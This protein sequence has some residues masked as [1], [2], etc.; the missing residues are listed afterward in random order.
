MT[1]DDIQEAIVYFAEAARRVKEAG[2]DMIHIHGAHGYLISSFL[3]PWANKRTDEYGGSL[4]NRARFPLEI[5]AAMRKVVGPDFPIGYRMSAEEYVEGGLTIKE[6]AEFSKMLAEAGI[7]LIDISGGIYESWWMIVHGPEAPKGGFVRCGGEIK[8]AV[9][10]KVPVSVAQKLTDPHF[11]NEAMRREGFDYVSLSRGFHTDPYYARRVEEGR[12][13]EIVPCTAC[14]HCTGVLDANLPVGCAS[15]PYTVYEKRRWTG[16]MVPAAKIV[17]V[18]GG[19]G[20]MSAAKILSEQGNQVILFEATGALGGQILYSVRGAPDYGD[21]TTYLVGQMSKLK[22]DVRLNSKASLDTIKD[23]RPDAVIVATGSNPGLKLWPVRGNARQF[24]IYSAMDR[25]DAEWKGRTVVL[26][27]DAV[28]CFVGLY[29]AGRGAE[30]HIVSPEKAF[31]LDKL[32][33]G[34]DLLLASLE[35]LPTVHMR[36]ESTVEDIGENYVVI[37]KAGAY[38]RFE[39]VESTVIGGRV[40]NY[41]LYEQILAELP[42]QEVYNIGDSLEP[43]DMN[44]ATHEAMEAAELIR[45]KHSIRTGTPQAA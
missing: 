12:I 16:K 43:R 8:K 29:L 37:Q 5:L 15:N 44:A 36:A 4:A 33:S 38:E 2:L 41:S 28:T 14:L 11:A 7:D 20:G 10:S 1:K 23:L 31:A 26:G 6:S 42:E 13:D 3:S 21:L 19:P 30:V 40:A 32:A 17:V 9:G 35:A 45:L 34:R 18:G 27:G 39:D 24:N 25:P 22:V